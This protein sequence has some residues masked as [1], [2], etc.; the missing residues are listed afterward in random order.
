MEL[1]HLDEKTRV[2]LQGVLYR[3]SCRSWWMA[4]VVGLLSYNFV[5]PLLSVL[6]TWAAVLVALSALSFSVVVAFWP[7]APL[8]EVYAALPRPEELSA[9]A[10]RAIDRS[11]DRL[12]DCLIAFGLAAFVLT[13]GILRTLRGL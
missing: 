1:E 3:S 10:K 5:A 8:W 2:G 11:G 4:G 6:A 13:I 9:E 7:T 12:G